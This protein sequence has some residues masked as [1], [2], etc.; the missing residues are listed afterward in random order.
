MN[1]AIQDLVKVSTVAG[2]SLS[3]PPVFRKDCVLTNALLAS[4][5][6]TSYTWT[7]ATTIKAG[8]YVLSIAQSGYVQ[9]F[10]FPSKSL[11]PPPTPS[12]TNYSPQ[13]P[14]ASTNTNKPAPAPSAAPPATKSF[15]QLS[16]YPQS[17]SYP[18]PTSGTWA[19]FTKL[20]AQA[21]LITADVVS[22]VSG[23]LRSST[24]P[25]HNND[26]GS[27]E[28]GPVCTKKSGDVTNGAVGGME[29]AG[30]LLVVG[31]WGVVGGLVFV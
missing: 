12:S 18:P 21:A 15:P 13:F 30:I 24:V 31:V 28:N 4:A 25:H 2:T 10:A 26:E 9:S 17:T 29:M 1:G 22:N 7:P 19:A 14:I 5:T 3:S 8:T 20:E 23:M 27:C 6:G 11:T 16:S